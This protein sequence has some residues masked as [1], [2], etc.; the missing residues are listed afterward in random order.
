MNTETE[1][2]VHHHTHEPHGKKTWKNYFWEFLMLF[3]AVFCGFLAE[4]QLE[5][6]IEHQ[7]EKEFIHSMIEDAQIDTVNIHRAI[8]FDKL[9]LAK[10]DTLATICLEGDS[11]ENQAAHMHR[12]Y[13][14][15]L[16]HPSIVSPTE[17]TMQQL[18]NSGGM[19]LIR[20][21][22]AIDAILKYDD[23]AKKILNQQ[24]YYERSGTKA[25]D[26]GCPIFNFKRI[27]EINSKTSH[28]KGGDASV[29]LLTTDKM[30]IAEF[31]N[32]I[33]VYQGIVHFYTV[34]LQEMEK[35]SVELMKILRE[36]YHLSDE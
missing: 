20:N 8:A 31:G 26:L 33:S 22:K 36:E 29:K 28:F 25:I 4:Y 21:K 2:E 35:Q 19:R 23:M 1:M 15:A 10:L 6:T 14:S 9:R 27:F 30:K 12:L 32:S 24:G 13:L 3:L 34:R 11:F 7:R 17:R 16:Y 18:K 5:H